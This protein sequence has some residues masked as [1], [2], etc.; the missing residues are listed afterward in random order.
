MAANHEHI[1]TASEQIRHWHQTKVY[2]IT[3]LIAIIG[4]G[5]TVAGGLVGGTSLIVTL[6]GEQIAQ[7][8]RSDRIET[9][10]ERDIKS[11]KTDHETDINK[12]EETQQR[13]I[14]KIDGRLDK[15]DGKLDKL[16]EWE[17]NRP[18]GP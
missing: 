4:L 14:Q 13:N 7:S 9:R 1:P 6:Q 2:N 16:I 12:V 10:I 5:F 8:K 15:M 18:R 11:L 3:T 17:I